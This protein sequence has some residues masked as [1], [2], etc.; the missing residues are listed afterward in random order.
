MAT[1]GIVIE[2]ITDREQWDGFLSAQPRG[3]LLQS[4]EWGELSKFLGNRIYRLG[5]LEGGQVRGVMLLT[6]APVPI[7]ARVPG[8]HMNWLYSARGPT[9]EQPD[10]PALAALVTHAHRIA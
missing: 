4:Y 5:A 3:H 10:S 7:P 1:T 9:S 2:E 6:V 8:V